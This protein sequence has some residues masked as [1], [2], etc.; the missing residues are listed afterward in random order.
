MGAQPPAKELKPG[1]AKSPGV[2]ASLISVLDLITG[3]KHFLFLPF[4][5]ENMASDFQ[6]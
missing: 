3:D 5:G 6:L 4:I 1:A 2:L